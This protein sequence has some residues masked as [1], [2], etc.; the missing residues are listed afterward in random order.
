MMMRTEQPPLI[1]LQDYRPPD[2]LVDTVHL[3]VS[4]HPTASR[5][6]AR[7]GLRPKTSAPAPVVLDGDGINLVSVAIDGKPLPKEAY[8][9][10]SER[11]TISQAPP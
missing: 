4:L 1:R 10:T 11:L 3:D 2:W 7:I 8:A 9:A 5:V 6:R